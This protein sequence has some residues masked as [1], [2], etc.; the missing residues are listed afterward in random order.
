MKTKVENQVVLVI[1]IGSNMAFANDDLSD[2]H[3]A[4]TI[5]AVNW[6][7]SR[8]VDSFEIN[9]ADISK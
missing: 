3:F 1:D 6:V 9:S 2:S 4:K 7:L 5:D 8:R